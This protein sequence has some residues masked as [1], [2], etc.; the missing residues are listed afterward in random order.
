MFG[1]GKKRKDDLG[2]DKDLDFGK[3]DLNLGFDDPLA[4]NRGGNQFMG[5]PPQ[6]SAP[7]QEFPDFGANQPGSFNDY[8]QH[9]QAQRPVYQEIGPVQQAPQQS[10][11][12]R[13]LQ[14]ISAKLDAIKSELDAM[15]QRIIKIEKIAD[16]EADKQARKKVW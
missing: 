3:D 11:F 14:L 2:L 10:G 6:H 7:P 12:E 1:F 8:S 9:Q 15:N 5:L 16:V 4:G 13:D